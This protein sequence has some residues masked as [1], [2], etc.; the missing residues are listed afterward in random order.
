MEEP[1]AQRPD[2]N[3]CA[4]HAGNGA[5]R[6]RRAPAGRGLR[7]RLRGLLRREGHSA[8]S[9]T[10]CRPATAA[11][12][13]STPMSISASSRTSSPRPRAW[14]AACPSARACCGG[15]AGRYAQQPGT[16]GSTFGGNPGV[17]AAGALRACFRALTRRLLSARWRKEGANT[18]GAEA[19]RHARDSTVRGM[20][21]MVGVLH[22]EEPAGE[23]VAR[24][25]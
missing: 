13:S 9:S 4:R 22:A 20:G 21:L 5:G 24:L 6:G 1:A 12:A 17:P 25:P 15:K 7:T 3:T 16:H 14:A 23:V 18:S 19:R 2:E 8:S 10:R 11:R